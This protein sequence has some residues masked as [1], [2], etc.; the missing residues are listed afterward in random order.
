MVVQGLT[1]RLSKLD[2]AKELEVSPTTIDRM[3]TRSRYCWPMMNPIPPEIHQK[4][5]QVNSQV[6]SHCP[7]GTNPKWKS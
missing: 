4:N 3:I 2:A 7:P 5:R 1:R 6:V